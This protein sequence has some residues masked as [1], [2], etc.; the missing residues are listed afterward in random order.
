VEVARLVNT[1][2]TN[3]EIAE[4]LRVSEHTV[5]RHMT[6]MLRKARQKNRTGLMA[7][8]HQ[9]RILVD[10]EDGP[11][12]TGRRCLRSAELGRPRVAT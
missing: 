2:L 8:L 6:S 12:P 9:E 7:A 3:A 4:R 1:G 11:E 10:G 5:V